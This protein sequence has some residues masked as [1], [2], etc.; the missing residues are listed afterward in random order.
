VYLGMIKRVLTRTR[1]LVCDL[2]SA[3]VQQRM[4]VLGSVKVCICRTSKLSLPISF[5]DCEK[6]SGENV[7][8][9]AE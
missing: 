6:T 1:L 2:Q 4:Q 7:E 9:A 3:C 5:S 8:N